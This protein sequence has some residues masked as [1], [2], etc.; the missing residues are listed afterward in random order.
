MHLYFEALIFV[1]IIIIIAFFPQFCFAESF[2]V[3][4]SG[5]DADGVNGSINTPWKTLQHAVDSIQGKSEGAILYLRGGMYGKVIVSGV[6]GL[7]ITSYPGE[8]AV[9][10][11]PPSADPNIYRPNTFEITGSPSSGLKVQN[12]EIAGGYYALKL[13][14]A[15]GKNVTIEN[16]KIHD[17]AADA[18]KIAGDYEYFYDFADGAIIQNNEIYNSGTLLSN[19]QGIDSIGGDG[20]VIRE[21]YIHDTKSE[22]ILVKMN[23]KN[24][25]V[26]R[27]KVVN[28]NTGAGIN[29]GQGGS[30]CYVYKESDNPKAFECTNCIARNNIIVNTRAAGIGLLGT[31]GSEVYNN[32]FV[33]IASNGQAGVWIY[34]VD[35]AFG[36][37]CH[38]YVRVVNENF[39]IINNIFVISS[40]RPGVQYDEINGTTFFASNIYYRPSGTIRF[41]SETD[42]EFNFGSWKEKF[43]EENSSEENPLL[44]TDF[45]PAS[46]NAIDKG[47][48]LQ[49]FNYDF[50]GGVRPVGTAWDIGAFEIGAA[51]NP[52]IN[53]VGPEPYPQPPQTPEPPKP[54][55][56]TSQILIFGAKF[57]E[58]MVRSIAIIGFPWVI[59]SAPIQVIFALLSMAG[60]VFAN[61]II[62]VLGQAL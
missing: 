20:I 16:C 60:I 34:S 44:G 13:N 61:E 1:F 32:T 57:L 4:P 8:N 30:D 49:G 62:K 28:S 29:F 43:G 24:A 14:G 2:Y 11:S 10:S 5:S 31:K 9:I 22:A 36:G 53:N 45:R 6:P 47:K 42:G 27:N 41:Y 19:G 25:L 35:N 58:S 21:N 18:I 23:A 46:K 50:E 48:T 3:S 37:D 59:F 55:V 7:T 15:S 54:S 26:E 12:L 52:D 51:Q 39:Q 17:S 56:Q 40:S 38:D 33:N